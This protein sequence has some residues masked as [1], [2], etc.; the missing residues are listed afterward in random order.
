MANRNSQLQDVAS[1]SV[2]MCFLFGV[3]VRAFEER[4]VPW[5][6][7]AILDTEQRFGTVNRPGPVS[8]GAGG[9]AS[10]I[11][12]H[13]ID[14]GTG[15]SPERVF[16]VSDKDRPGVELSGEVTISRD[17]AGLFDPADFK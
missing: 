4:S 15:L 3:F 14:G 8:A 7:P 16:P 11:F 9:P 6:D 12:L 17:T 5:G 2:R 10:T 1:E 13:H